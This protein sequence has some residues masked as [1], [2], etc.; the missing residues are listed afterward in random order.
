MPDLRTIAKD[1]D[2]QKLPIEEQRKAFAEYYKDFARLPVAEQDN[3]IKELTG[4]ASS[5][6]QP[7]AN[8]IPRSPGYFSRV[9]AD[10]RQ[11]LR[12]IG[13]EL[14]NLWEAGKPGGGGPHEKKLGL[15]GSI[16]DIER[17]L[18]HIEGE[19]AGGVTDTL[20]NEPLKSLWNVAGEKGPGSP[21]LKQRHVNRSSGESWSKN[22][23]PVRSLSND[24]ATDPGWERI[25]EIGLG[26]LR[27]GGA[28]WDLFSKT[29][30]EAAKVVREWGED[31]NAVGNIAQ[32]VPLL[33][34]A[35]T[36]AGKMGAI[37]KDAGGA[38]AK[39]MQ[40]KAATDALESEVKQTFTK[41]FEKG[42]AGTAE[43]TPKE[44]F[45]AQKHMRQQE[46]LRLL[47]AKP[48]SQWNDA[49]K[50]FMREMAEEGPAVVNPASAEDFIARRDKSSRAQFL[51]PYTAEDLS[52]MRLQ[53]I[54]GY[55]AGYALKS[56]GEIVNA[57]NN[58][59]VKDVGPVLIADAVSK[60][61][62]KLSCFELYLPEFYGNMG[63]KEVTRDVWKDQY[64]P[65]GWNYERDDRPD[66]VYM[67]WG[68]EGT[69]PGTI[70]HNFE[71]RRGRPLDVNPVTERFRRQSQPQPA[72]TT[73]P[74][75][76]PG[77]QG[78]ASGRTRLPQ[79][80]SVAPPEQAAGL[81]PKE[82]FEARRQRQE[83]LKHLKIKKPG[84]KE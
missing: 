19:I 29:Y 42:I 53:V 63:F 31:I 35:G 67:E 83:R 48:L 24:D 7:E 77:V 2:F 44:R 23:T 57:F 50:A 22:F 46:R 69:D 56:D 60:G 65:R 25:K 38:A 9:G 15:P 76:A 40:R 80:R 45:E 33:R 5:G 16:L 68:G 64:A 26:A 54:Q 58:S 21:P 52:S 6:T 1:R 28:A 18:L 41:G 79:E 73:R 75:V 34:A 3:W 49:D 62:R 27:R 55:D 11:R 82:R 20:L 8:T 78:G 51:T 14:G 72:S 4:R 59:N 12:N 81:T 61:G 13:G 36:V 66:I 32:A 70:L 43:L 39:A 37:V 84:D 47:S 10:W 71:T 74:P 30:P 17:P